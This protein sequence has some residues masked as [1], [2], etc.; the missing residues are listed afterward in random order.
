MALSYQNM[1][2]AVQTVLQ[3]G[4]VPNIVGEAGIGKS[5]LVADVAQQLKAKLFT[6][7]VSL[8]EKGDLAIPVPPLRNEAFIKTSN[9][10]TLANVQY[11]YSETL[12][13]IIRYAEKHP[14]KLI[15]WFLDEFNRGTAAVQSELMNVVLQ[16][17]VNSLQLPEQVKIIIAENPD[18]SMEGF[19]DS[20]YA[21]T[22]ADNAIKDRT[23]RLIMRA[24]VND[25][26]LWASQDG[27]DGQ[28]LIDPLVQKYIKENPR[29]LATLN[30]LTDIHP[31]PRAWH[32]VS[33]N[34]R[35]LMKLPSNEQQALMADVFAGDLGSEIGV[36]FARFVMENGHQLTASDLLKAPFTEV[37]NHFDQLS[38]TDRVTLLQQLFKDSNQ[39]LI[40]DDQFLDRFLS[41]LKGI[42]PDGQYAIGK[43][44]GESESMTH[45]LSNLYQKAQN[46]EKE[47]AW[48]T[49]RLLQ[50]IAMR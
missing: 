40:A 23:V 28:S 16:R 33:R 22:P 49:Y 35:Q 19:E 26:L 5:A 4:N 37:K 2:Q 36:A 9:Y 32:R 14:E 24:N 13:S 38:Q 8:S 11:G 17:R 34:L 10:G 42:S 1:K 15:I 25:W 39:Q 48:Q 30:N 21:V 12:V 27:D 6:T 50:D 29:L 41:L 44:I 45:F 43:L 7:V 46:T 20:D 3:A 31:T 47:P 18:S